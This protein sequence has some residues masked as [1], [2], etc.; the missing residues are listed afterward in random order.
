[1]TG[2]ILASRGRPIEKPSAPISLEGVARGVDISAQRSW[3][4][5]IALGGLES[6]SAPAQPAKAAP[7]SAGVRVSSSAGGPSPQSVS[8]ADAIGAGSASSASPNRSESI[9]EDAPESQRKQYLLD[10][11]LPSDPDAVHAALDLKKRLQAMFDKTHYEILGIPSNASI[12]TIRTAYFELAKTYHVDKF[13]NV[14]LGEY[15][16]VAEEVFRKISEAS[17]V[18]SDENERSN[19]DVFLD[20]KEKGLP[21]DVNLILEA[22]NLFQRAKMLVSRGNGARALPDLERA[23]E[24]NN[25][26]LDYKTYYA[27]AKY[28]AEGGASFSEAR[29][30]LEGVVSK[31]KKNSTAHD[32]LGRIHRTEGNLKS[33]AQH[34]QKAIEIAPKNA[35]ALRELR[36]VQMRLNK[37]DDEGKGGFLKGLL[38][39]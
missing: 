12:D 17:R 10:L 16:K 18:L 15:G 34:L 11:P 28:L 39:R 33:A 25:V 19:Y 9:P 31:D 7:E 3:L 30:I 35:E 8:V 32:F 27:Y 2:E 23:I 14:S 37:K 36:V 13:S 4:T 26:D 22:D 38:K 29:E 6:A 21:T 20:R 5:L 24:L 1:M